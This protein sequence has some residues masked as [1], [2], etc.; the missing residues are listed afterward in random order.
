[1][2]SSECAI[3]RCSS[4]LED[5]GKCISCDKGFGL[6]GIC[7]DETECNRCIK[8]GNKC[9]TCHLCICYECEKGYTINPKSPQNC[10]K[11]E[12]PFDPLHFE[13]YQCTNSTS[14]SF[15]NVNSFLLI[16]FIILIVIIF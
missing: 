7:I 15:I 2:G 12:E 1:M 13:I 9:K 5:N 14:S 3:D 10:I 16:I 6:G 11:G 4:C 8:C